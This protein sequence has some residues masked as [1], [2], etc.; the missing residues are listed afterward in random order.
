[1]SN[2]FEVREIPAEMTRSL[3]HR[4]LWPHIEK[5]EDCVIDIDRREDAIHLGTFDGDRLISVGSLFAMSSPRLPHEKQYRLR[6]MATD[7]DYRGRDAGRVL[8]E[9]AMNVLGKKGIDVLWCDARLHATGFYGKLGF[10]KFEDVYEVRNI[11]PHQ[12]MWVEL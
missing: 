5:E 2:V 3:R 6:A 12:F 8:I 7:P 9:Y 1:M 11:G 4:V 10:S